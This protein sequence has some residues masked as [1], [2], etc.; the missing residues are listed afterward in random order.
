MIGTTMHFEALQQHS[1]VR[2]V[3]DDGM[4]VSQEAG[5]K[6]S[7]DASEEPLLDERQFYITRVAYG[8]AHTLTWVEQLHHAV[9]F[10]AQFNYERRTREGGVNRFHHLIYNVENYLVRLQSVYDRLLQLTNNVFHICTSDELVNHGL[11]VSNLHVA[12]TKVPQ[13]LRAVRKTLEPQATARNDIVHK[14]SYT[15]P[16]LRRLELFYM[17]TEATWGSSDRR[18]PFKNLAHVRAQLM[19]QATTSKRT[20]FAA[21]NAALV[22]ALLLLFTELNVQYSRQKARVSAAADA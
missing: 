22:K 6:P 13:L 10:L 17:Q 21:M 7:A 16:A 2:T 19:K 11:I 18:L 4:E 1:F 3:F 5:I 15:D 9:H 14:H 8:L 12:R 20:E